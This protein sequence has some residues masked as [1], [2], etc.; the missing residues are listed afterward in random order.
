MFIITYLNVFDYKLQFNLFYRIVE[1]KFAPL[2]DV[3]CHGR[4]EHR[5]AHAAGIAASLVDH[6]QLK[7]A[8]ANQLLAKKTSH[9]N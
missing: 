9:Q 1:I 6:R 4:A 8:N 5:A 3:G 7:L 2:F